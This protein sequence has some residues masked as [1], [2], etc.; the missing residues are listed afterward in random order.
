M[1]IV[2]LRN[3]TLSDV[4]GG[5]GGGGDDDDDDDDDDAVEGP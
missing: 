1:K 2:P 5:G 4:G 3:F